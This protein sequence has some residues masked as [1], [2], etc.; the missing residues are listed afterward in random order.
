MYLNGFVTAA[1]YVVYG[2]HGTLKSYYKRI[3]GLSVFYI[4]E[5]YLYGMYVGFFVYIYTSYQCSLT[6]KK[7]PL[8]TYPL[9]I[10]Y[11]IYTRIHG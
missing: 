2:W 11:G 1:A 9:S 3:L 8:Y 5:I 10:Y 7:G 6:D 4:Y